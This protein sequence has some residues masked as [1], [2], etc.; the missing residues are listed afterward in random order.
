MTYELNVTKTGYTISSI[1]DCSFWDDFNSYIENVGDVLQYAGYTSDSKPKLSLNDKIETVIKLYKENVPYHERENKQ[2]LFLK[3]IKAPYKRLTVGDQE[4]MDV[5]GYPP[6]HKMTKA[7]E[8]YDKYMETFNSV[9]QYLENYWL[10]KAACVEDHED[11]S[12]YIHHCMDDS[13]LI[14]MLKDTCGVEIDDK[15][16]QEIWDTL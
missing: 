12:T 4:Y 10:G 16:A 7:W 14:V 5:V 2:G 1:D 6:D 11:G 9:C 13:D 3:A 15:K 8:S